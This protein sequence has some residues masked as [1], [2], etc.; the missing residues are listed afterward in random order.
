MEPNQ[1]QN[2]VSSK[3]SAKDF[4]INLGAIVA[5]AFF[6]GNL[7]NLLFT[8]I[9]KA[10]PLTTGSN[11]SE[12]SSISFPVASLI[13]FFPVYILLMWLLEKDYVLEPGK[14]NIGIRKWLTYITLFVSGFALAGDL[15]TVLFYFIDGRDITS[16]F[17]LKA[18]SVL[19]ISLS[20]FFYYISEVRGKMNSSLQKRWAIGSAI[21]IVVCIIWGFAVL[22]SPRTQQLLKYDE[23]KVN[24]LQNIEGSIGNFYATKGVLPN[25]FDE[26]LA[27]NYYINTID[28]QTQKPYE[29]EKTN[30]VTYN[31]CAEFN[32]EI[33]KTDIKGGQLMV[34]GGNTWIHGAG[35]FCFNKTI[36]PNL[37]SK[38]MPV[39]VR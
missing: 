34:Y 11:F 27:E 16:G 2:Q 15:V 14:R 1:I 29:Y 3:T 24:D 22:G 4:F 28:S 6:V 19:I 30:K 17:I 26:L 31:L 37:Y 9:N 39:P 32:R 33:T 38:P 23:Q 5:L 18:L 12:S 36:N 7:I 10:F 8:I 20:I 21:V 25:N 13:I 35:R